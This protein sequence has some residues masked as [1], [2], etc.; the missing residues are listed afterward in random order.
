MCVAHPVHKQGIICMTNQDLWSTLKGGGCS[1]LSRKGEAVVANL[2][3]KQGFRS[4]GWSI[5][6]D[7]RISESGV[8]L[9]CDLP[10]GLTS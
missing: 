6:W 9:I 5:K 4:V 1:R 7:H 8:Q 10:R 3:I 2:L